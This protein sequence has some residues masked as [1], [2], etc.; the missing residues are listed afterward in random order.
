VLISFTAFLRE[1]GGG[2]GD[3]MTTETK[4]GRWEK[5]EGGWSRARKDGRKVYHI[6][7]TVNG[8]AYAISTGCTTLKAAMEHLKKFE[9]DP[10][11]YRPG[12]DEPVF[13]DERL[14]EEL[15]IWSRDVKRNS[16][17]H[18][19][20][21]GRYL[22]WWAEV[23]R[24]VDLRRASLQDH[25]LPPLEVAGTARQQRI[26]IIKVVYSFLRKAVHRIKT[27]EDPTFGQ[28]MVP[29]SKPEQARRVGAI[30]RAACER[31]NAREPHRGSEAGH[32]PGT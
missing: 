2:G 7:R 11:G 24:G 27:A 31:R 19:Y 22:A 21:Q 28:L 10:A 8:R 4:T 25:I 16:P 20:Q 29:Q 9:A 18:I 15:L 1:S 23:L 14:I 30:A 6:R 32:E 12:G 5:W 17:R 3:A 13:L 26:A